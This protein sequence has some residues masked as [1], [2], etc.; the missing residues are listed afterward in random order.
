MNHNPN[1]PLI[2]ANAGTQIIERLLFPI[3]RHPGLVPGPAVSAEALPVEGS[4]KRSHSLDCALTRGPRHKA[5]VTD[6]WD[7]AEPYNLGPG[8]RRDERKEERL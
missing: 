4:R 7:S 8:I 6:K 3:F 2:P 1:T 5:G